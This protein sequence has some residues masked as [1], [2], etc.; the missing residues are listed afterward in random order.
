MNAGKSRRRTSL[1]ARLLSLLVLGLPLFEVPAGSRARRLRALHLANR[2]ASLGQHALLYCLLRDQRWAGL[3][4]QESRVALERTQQRLLELGAGADN[5]QPLLQ[6]YS[7]LL[8]AANDDA[9]RACALALGERVLERSLAVVEALASQLATPEAQW[10]SLCGRIYAYSQRALCLLAVE[11]PA[12]L[13]LDRSSQLHSCHAQCR[14]TLDRLR[15]LTQ[16]GADIAPLLGELQK[17]HQMP[18][19]N[20]DGAWLHHVS[21]SLLHSL[22]RLEEIGT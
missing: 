17:L 21:A 14:Q 3:H 18:P 12:A 22:Q 6:G 5:L 9:L 2:Q 19:D 11:H 1:P 10:L 20:P 7:L 13:G 8:H 16:H 15:G 4:L